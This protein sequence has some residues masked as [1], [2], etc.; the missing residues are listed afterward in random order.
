MLRRASALT[1]LAIIGVAWASDAIAASDDMGRRLSA[2]A[3][4]VLIGDRL[5][6]ETRFSQYFYSNAEGNVNA[7]LA[8]GDPLV[9]KVPRA[10]S[11]PLPGPFRGQ[12]ISCRHCHLGDDFL[13]SVPLAQR[14]YADFSQRT[15][16]PIRNDG[17]TRTVR[18]TPQ[19]VDLGLRREV[20]RLFHYDG[21]FAHAEDL[22]IGT[23]TGRNM[24]WQFAERNIAVSHIANVI[25]NDSGINARH[26]RTRGGP[27]LPY[28]V[29]LLGTDASIPETLRLLPRYRIDAG[30]AADLDVLRAVARLVHAYM[31]SIRF[32]TEDTGRPTGSPYDL[33][34]RKNGLPSGP[35]K[36]ETNIQYARRLA[37]LLEKK[38]QFLWVSSPTD[39]KFELHRQRYEFGESELAGFRIF[40]SE[41]SR[42][43]EAEHVGACVLCHTPPQFTDHGFHNTGISQLEYDSLFG[44]GAFAT[45]EIPDLPK[46]AARP[47]LYL[48][49][50]AQYSQRVGRFRSA[51]ARDK[52]GYADL[53][54][55]NIFANPEFPAPQSALTTI[56]CSSSSPATCSAEQLLPRTIALFKTPTLR[57]LG[58]SDPY[59]HSGGAK[60]LEDV[61]EHYT[62]AARLARAD[63]LRNGASELK[64]IRLSTV[65]S[66]HLLAFLKTL[67]EDY[68]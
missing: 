21:E 61:L 45:L 66:Q 18:N 47:N 40:L 32:G 51:P 14:T 30:A 17:L 22:V 43:R 23:L 20:P 5:F 25:R 60:T 56:L 6:F 67:N 54:V 7:P 3:P 38:T 57:D 28:K 15:A 34:L 55:W 26:V 24:G 42:P 46:R 41:S 8:A 9:Q 44:A 37:R 12:S 13:K 11:A 35:E 39:G 4:E 10:D 68:H 50:S 53:G 33:F 16:I 27:G 29:V 31:D 1:S 49:A 58:H 59:F 65:T 52:P 48:P 63:K 62:R 36:D 64:V 2:G 19:M